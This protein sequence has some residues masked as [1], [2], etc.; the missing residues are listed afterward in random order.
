[1][2]VPGICEHILARTEVL[3]VPVA[4]HKAEVWKARGILI[5]QSLKV[6]CQFLL[7]CLWVCY[8]NVE[9]RCA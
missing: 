5:A 4:L 6:C 9:V 7:T 1:M 2:S 8:C 3:L